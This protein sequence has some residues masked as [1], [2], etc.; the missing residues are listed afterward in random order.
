VSLCLTQSLSGLIAFTVLVGVVL[1]ER[2]QIR[3]LVLLVTTLGI[4]AA[5]ALSI[6]EFQDRIEKLRSGD[7]DSANIRMLMPL[8]IISSM[9]SQQMVVG[10]TRREIFKKS[11][12]NGIDNG[13]YNFI[14]TYGLVSSFAVIAL[15]IYFRKNL[16]IL[17]FLGV[18]ASFNGLIFG[19]DKAVVLGAAIG[20]ILQRDQL[21]GDNLQRRH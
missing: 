20:L 15:G 19:Y 1:I 13:I 7:D 18:C 8:E 16:K 3:S 5:L 2:S 6:P 21:L 11:G 12:G 10:M 17:V 9:N 14:L 4:G